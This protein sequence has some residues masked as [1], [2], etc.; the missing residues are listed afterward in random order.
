MDRA[1]ASAENEDEKGER[2]GDTGR[3]ENYRPGPAAYLV[4]AGIE[5]LRQPGSRDPRL[6]CSREGINIDARKGLVS[7][8]PFPHRN[9]PIGI[10]IVQKTVTVGQ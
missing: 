2:S 8:D 7:K 9:M 5:N 1:N 10:G 6:A 3:S 4:T